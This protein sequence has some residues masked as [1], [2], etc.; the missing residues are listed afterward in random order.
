MIFRKSNLFRKVIDIF[1]SGDNVFL[2]IS[3][4]ARRT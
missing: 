1:G 4:F 2:F 3:N